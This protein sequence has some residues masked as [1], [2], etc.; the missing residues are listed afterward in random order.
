[1]KMWNENGNT[2]IL[3]LSLKG[4]EMLYQERRGQGKTI[5]ME[6]F[7]IILFHKSGLAKKQDT[8][9]SSIC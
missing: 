2:T 5:V 9:Q 3:L 6:S 7:N 4:L 8:Y 1:M